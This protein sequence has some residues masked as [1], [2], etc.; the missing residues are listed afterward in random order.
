V[1]VSDEVV[2][3]RQRLERFFREELQSFMERG[4]L[5][6]DT[7]AALKTICHALLWACSLME[8]HAKHTSGYSEFRDADPIR[9]VVAGIRYGRNRALHQFP[10]LLQISNGARFPLQFPAPFFEIEWR[11]RRLLP[12]PDPGFDVAALA[13][14]YE[15]HLEGKSVRVTLKLLDQFFFRAAELEPRRHE[16]RE[17]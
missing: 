15:A 17:V 16:N 9:G 1:N 14:D 4:R 11:P 6:R 12:L 3:T 2:E 8:F 5:Q 7:E 10:Q 13:R